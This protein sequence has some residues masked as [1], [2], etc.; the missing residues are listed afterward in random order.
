MLRRPKP[1]DTEEDILTMQEEFMKSG[2]LPSANLSKS[3]ANK[4]G[5]HLAPQS[6]RRVEYTAR[7]TGRP[8]CSSR[9]VTLAHTFRNE[10]G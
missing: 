5:G 6:I 3:G 8:T 9:F 2:S 4:K 7:T 1:E 10:G